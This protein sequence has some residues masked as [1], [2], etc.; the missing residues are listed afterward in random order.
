[1]GRLRIVYAGAESE[2]AVTLPVRWLA[3]ATEHGLF[4]GAEAAGEA[5][6][7]KLWDA[8]GLLVGH[9]AMRIA[10]A[11]VEAAA[12]E[13]YRR[14]FGACA[15]RHLYR[16][17]NY[18]PAINDVTNG[19]ENYRAFCRGR[20]LAFER[21]LGAGF[22]RELSSASAV[23]AEGGELHAIFAAG[24]EAGRHVE[25]PEQVPAYRYP[26]E[27]GPRAPSFARA[28][29]VN[30]GGREIVFLSGTAAIKGHES[31]GRGDLARQLACTLDNLRLISRAAGMG[32]RLRRGDAGERHFKVYLRNAADLAA[33]R[34][35]LE[36]ELFEP[37]DRISY[38]RAEVCRAELL[39]E[40]EATVVR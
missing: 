22:E 18:V 24:T 38:L 25:N 15:G 35:M 4:A 33:A 5:E 39:V 8:G 16:V 37:G 20:S 19:L 30:A 40:I 26:A 7:F 2:A 1:V 32:D 34:A 10:P 14:M 17:W 27:H 9:A 13:L 12:S 29:V 11:G 6:G 3:G 23:G 36:R 28:T 31:V 21:E